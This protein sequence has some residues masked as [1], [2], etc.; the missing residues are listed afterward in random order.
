MDLLRD[1]LLV[2]HFVGFGALFGG[3]AVQ[4]RDEIK[5]VNAGM[6]YG[7]LIQVVSGILLVGVAEGAGDDVKS[8]KIGVK[9]AVA[10]LISVLCWVNRRKESVP[11]GLFFAILGLTLANVVIAVFW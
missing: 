9:L 6:L 1:V 11:H 4:A 5:V 7:A 2:I 10:L 3:A 8:A